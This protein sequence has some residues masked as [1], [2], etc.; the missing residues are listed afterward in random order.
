[1]AKLGD[2][3][4][5]PR[6][7]RA[8]AARRALALVLV[9]ALVFAGVSPAWA[10]TV[11]VEAEGE[12]G[13]PPGVLPGLEEGPELGGE[14]TVLGEEAPFLPGEEGEEEVPPEYESPPPP[15]APPPAPEASTPVA[16]EIPVEPEASPATP[17]AAEPVYE[18]APGP[19][20]RTETPA[21]AVV[22][23]E[24]LVAPPSAPPRSQDGG[25]GGRAVASP[26]SS[27]APSRAAP[28][29]EAPPPAAP[30]IEAPE[31]APVPPA[32]PAEPGALAGRHLHAVRPGE[33]LWSIAKALL[34]VGASSARIAAEVHRL[35]HLNA[36]RIGTGDPS[37]IFV[38][39]RLRL[40][41][42]IR[43]GR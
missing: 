29:A 23:G 5:I 10:V 32:E 34:P 27:E 41:L 30:P 11:E 39:T 36:A 17:P 40:G 6:R 43:A 8:L 26:P 2:I 25:Q 14:E 1:M 38:G 16:P 7:R 9:V 12:G 31:P 33:S 24:S 18:S 28:P 21:P 13:A 4:A 20:Y 19:E 3:G 22:H 37:L 15:E 42:G 35:W